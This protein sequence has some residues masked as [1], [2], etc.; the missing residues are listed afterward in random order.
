MVE[1]DKNHPS[2]VMWSLGN[3]S[4][5]GPNHAAMAGWI[6]ANDPTR[7]VHYEGVAA[8]PKDPP[9][10][11]VISRMY[12][13]IQKLAGMAKDTADARPIMLC[14]YAYARGNAV[15]NLQ[16]YWD[17]IKSEPRLIGAFLWDWQD[18]AFRK[19][20]A[21][22]RE[23]WAYGGDYGDVPN[24]GT[25]VANG[26]VLPDRSPEPEVYEV[27]K[28]Y[29][30]ITTRAVDAATGR[31]QVTNE[32]DF[33][34]LDF[35]DAAWDVTEDGRVVGRGT[36]AVPPVAPGEEGELALPLAPLPRQA[37]GT[38]R[39]L[40]V[41]Y[42]LARDETWAARGHVV[43]WEQ[44]P[45]PAGQAVEPPRLQTL[46]AL[47]MEET[48]AA[49]LVTGRGFSVA[50]GRASGA[51]ESFRVGSRELVAG[52]LVPNFWRV[53]LDNDIGQF[54]NDMPKRCAIWK[55]SG[56]GRTVSAVRAERLARGAVRV[57]VD[58][59]LPAG[60]S[61]YATTYTVHGNGDVVIESRFTPGQEALPEL[62]RFGMQ[63]AVRPELNTMTWLGRGPHENYWDRHTGAAVGR[64]SGR[65]ADLVHD[66]VRP[67]ENGN[68]TDVRWVALTDASGIG[69]LASGLPLLSVSA[70]PY[71]MDELEKATHV[72]ELPHRHDPGRATPVTL[73][74]D[75]RQTGVGGDNGWGA[76]PHLEYT[77]VPRQYEYRFLLRGYA[78]SMGTLDEVARRPVAMTRP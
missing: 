54:V 33:R 68:R 67:Q 5:T 48:P 71:S 69:L 78:P 74:L 37:S 47:E 20:D 52:P 50:I 75:Y 59:V 6:H 58:A 13:P 31:L 29:Q 8:L 43:A 16:D 62:P 27:Q 60:R 73:N 57:S 12:T 19:K 22:G 7:P 34:P 39:F 70:W 17:V 35:V 36:V 21:A 1:R 10:V 72:N 26:I 15:G 2:V 49:F 61:A 18:K 32:F 23:F 3:E 55:A 9:W 66:Y 28:V 76:R 14:E 56:P 63:M 65:V 44:F 77:V 11:D 30:Q 41:R 38:E 51:L 53:P 45:L 24:D 42:Q 64:Y 46:P 25:M 40:N 4:G